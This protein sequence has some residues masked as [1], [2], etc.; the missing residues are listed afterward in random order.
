[1]PSE[2]L[3]VSDAQQSIYESSSKQ[4]DAL[5]T[6][7]TPNHEIESA[8]KLKQAD[9]VDFT[10]IMSTKYF[11]SWHPD[12]TQGNSIISPC[13]LSYQNYRYSVIHQEQSAHPRVK[14]SI[15]WTDASQR[16][17]QH[18]LLYDNFRAGSVMKGVQTGRHM[19][20]MYRV[21]VRLL[22]VDWTNSQLSGYMTI[23][24]LVPEHAELTTFFAGQIMGPKWSFATRQWGINDAVDGK[25]W[26]KFEEFKELAPLFAENPNF[27]LCHRYRNRIDWSISGIPYEGSNEG[28]CHGSDRRNGESDEHQENVKGES[29]EHQG[30]GNDAPSGHVIR[31]KAIFMRWKE[32]FMVPDH[33]VTSISSASFEGLYYIC[34][35]PDLHK[36]HGYYQEPP[37]PC[38]LQVPSHGPSHVPLN[39]QNIMT[40]IGI[41]NAARQPSMT[42]AAATIDGSLSNA[43]SSVLRWPD[44]QHSGL[45]M[46]I[47]HSAA[48]G[49]A[50]MSEEQWLSL[51]TQHLSM[52]LEHGNELDGSLKSRMSFS[53]YSW[54]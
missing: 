50:G 28:D 5:N 20:D 47:N 27:S 30:N 23:Y 48:A 15:P 35:R 21:D 1:M 40:S 45:P 8:S 46:M 32:L 4:E 13:F 10:S 14:Q 11:P 54:R 34:Y 52:T 17:G 33:R 6:L 19:A 9:Y 41:S 29:D 38:Q 37:L 3:A 49:A 7:N 2:Q 42:T 43:V 36:L 25:Q 26:S 39:G 51:N 16:N 53:S 24:N 44:L 22:E 12:S 18:H 31:P